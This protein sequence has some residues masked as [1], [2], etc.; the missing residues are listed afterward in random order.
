MAR[1]TACKG[2]PLPGY[3]A[4]LA[5]V[6]SK[7]RYHEKLKFFGGKHQ[8]EIPRDAWK[9]DVD[10]WQAVTYINVGMYLFFFRQ[11]RTLERTR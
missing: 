1:E 2:A 8:Y 3:Q 10:P 9:V 4:T 7:E 5:D 11:V 6:R